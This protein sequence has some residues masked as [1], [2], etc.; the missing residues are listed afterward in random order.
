MKRYLF[1]LLPFLLI[2][3]CAESD[4][5]EALLQQIQTVET[6]LYEKP[7]APVDREKAAELVG[8]YLE[9]ADAYH[10]DSL[11]PEY[12]FR[13][14]DITSNLFEP[15]MAV[16]YLDRLMINYPDYPRFSRVLFTKAFVLENQL[17][18]MDLARELYE[19]FLIRFPEDVL[20]KD[21]REALGNIGKTPEE[22][23]R[24][25]EKNQAANKN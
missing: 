7:L 24:E 14:A 23:I 4:P 25:F 16:M 9:Y 17:G 19:E 10:A 6:A 18:K 3:G 22:L 2:A 11:S 1:L 13:A 21:V 5:R 20:A 8:Y 15:G 12:L